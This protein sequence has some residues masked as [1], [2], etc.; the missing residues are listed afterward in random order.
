MRCNKLKRLF[1]TIALRMLPKLWMI[2]I[3]EAAQLDVLFKHESEEGIVSGEEIVLPL[4]L[5]PEELEEKVIDY[6]V[7]NKSLNFYAFLSQYL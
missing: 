3:S 5:H 7:L 4:P 6:S 2:L 1:L